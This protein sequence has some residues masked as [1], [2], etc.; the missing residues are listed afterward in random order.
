M[1]ESFLFLSTFFRFSFT[2]ILVSGSRASLLARR[3][4]FDFLMMVGAAFNFVTIF[5]ASA[6]SKEV[7]D[8]PGP[9]ENHGL[10]VLSAIN[11]LWSDSCFLQVFS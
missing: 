3:I 6:G 4:S 1:G 7:P 11:Y 5:L 2:W 10:Q 8:S 9:Q